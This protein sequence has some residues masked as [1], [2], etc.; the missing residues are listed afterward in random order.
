[1]DTGKQGLLNTVSSRSVLISKWG[2]ILTGKL[3]M[4]IKGGIIL[5]N[6]KT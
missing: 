4:L 3:I 1:M 5:N 2:I 6:M